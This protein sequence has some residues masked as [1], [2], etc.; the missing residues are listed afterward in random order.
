M[1]PLSLSPTHTHTHTH[2]N[3]YRDREREAS[4]VNQLDT[5]GVWIAE[6][7]SLLPYASS[8]SFLGKHLETLRASFLSLPTS[9]LHTHRRAHTHTH[10][11]TCAHRHTQTYTHTPPHI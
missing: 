1:L 6:L 11:H 3:T 2:T 9:S 10:T 8:R 7:H 4:R 5:P